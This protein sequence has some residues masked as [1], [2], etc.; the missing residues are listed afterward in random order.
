MI[1]NPYWVAV[2]NEDW[3]GPGTNVELTSLAVAGERVTT[4]L[5]SLLL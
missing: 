1:K 5:L 2:F 4:L 3:M